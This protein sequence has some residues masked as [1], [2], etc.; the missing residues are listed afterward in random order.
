MPIVRSG[1]PLFANMGALDTASTGL[2][3]FD[4]SQRSTDIVERMLQ[5]SPGSWGW[6]CTSG[7]WSRPHVS[8]QELKSLR[9]E[10]IIILGG[11]RMV[12]KPNLNRLSKWRTTSFRG[13]QI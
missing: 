9:P 1:E 11:P 10:L 5:A 12:L 8:V 2:M 7:T 3:E 6:G 13:K 4:I